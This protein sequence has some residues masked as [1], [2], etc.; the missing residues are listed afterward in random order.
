MSFFLSVCGWFFWGG[1][2]GNVSRII[3][4]KESIGGLNILRISW[5]SCLHITYLKWRLTDR[6]VALFSSMIGGTEVANYDRR[7]V[8]S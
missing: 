1:R 3:V 4:F 8:D 5:Q 6:V 7:L 2:V